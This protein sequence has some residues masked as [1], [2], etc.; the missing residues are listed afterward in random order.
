MDSNRL[1]EP[2]ASNADPKSDFAL[3]HTTYQ[4]DPILAEEKREAES[5]AHSGANWFFW[6]AGLSLINSVIQLMNGTWAFIVGLGITQLI[7]GL[8][9]QIS[10]EGGSTPKIIALVLD[11]I[12]A[13][14][15]VFFGLL[16]RNRQGWAFI[17]GMILYILDGLLF[18]WVQDWLSIAFHIFALYNIFQG[19]RANNR[20]NELEREAASSKMA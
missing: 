8:A 16:A 14:V 3:P 18:V 5:R 17:V 7:D 20:L 11:V 15:F 13:G 9:T 19:F 6:I 2:A 10:T 4:E 1:P 12:V